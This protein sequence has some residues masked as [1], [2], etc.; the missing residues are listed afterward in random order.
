MSAGCCSAILFC[1]EVDPSP[2]A[3]DGSTLSC[4]LIFTA[5]HSASVLVV[6][7]KARMKPLR[8]NLRPLT[9]LWA[10][11]ASS[12][13]ISGVMPRNTHSS[14]DLGFTFTI[15]SLSTPRIHI[16]QHHTTDLGFTFTSVFHN[17]LHLDLGFTFTCIQHQ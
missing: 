3:L 1:P 10:L 12:S 16:H 9:N 8:S 17:I 7:L 2:A 6:G 11:A 15:I 14:S 13:T 5:R 4:K